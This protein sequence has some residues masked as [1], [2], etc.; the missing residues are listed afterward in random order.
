MSLWGAEPRR[1]ISTGFTGNEVVAVVG[2]PRCNAAR[3]I[4][5]TSK[6]G[7]PN[8][9]YPHQARRKAFLKQRAKL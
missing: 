1:L 2:C 7:K 4:R 3:G 6:T 9:V 5:C 8:L